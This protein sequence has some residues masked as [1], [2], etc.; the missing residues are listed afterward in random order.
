MSVLT[1]GVDLGGTNTRAGAVT[2]GG[3]VV[4]RSRRPT[5]LPE[6]AGNVAQLVPVG[7]LFRAGGRVA[8]SSPQLRAG[9]LTVVEGNERLFPGAPLLPDGGRD[10]GRDGAQNE[11]GR[12]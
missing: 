10:A 8:V 4:G 2:A 6:G 11:E 9:A 5:P 12:R 3:E 7:A 1:I